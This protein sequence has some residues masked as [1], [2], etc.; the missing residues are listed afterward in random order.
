MYHLNSQLP[1]PYELQ[2]QMGQMPQQQSQMM[3]RGGRARH[4]KMI[5]A[6]G[7]PHELDILDHLQ[8]GKVECPKTGLRSYPHL[9]EILKNP[10]IKANVHHHAMQHHAAGGH[11]VPELQHLAHA[12]RH[13]DSEMFLMGPHTHHI[14][15]QLAGHATRN[16]HTGHPEYWSLGGALGGLWNGIKG[17]AGHAWNGIKGIGKA[18]APALINMGQSY[19]NNKFGDKFGGLAK[20]G[21]NALGGYAKSALDNGG[22]QNPIHQAIGEGLGRGAQALQGGASASQAFGQ[23]M[24]HAGQ[25]FGGG[26]LGSAMQG[27]GS[28]LAQGQGFGEAMKQGANQGFQGMGGNQ[29]MMDAAKNIISSYGKPGGMQGALGQQMQQIGNRALPSSEGMNNLRDLEEMPFAGQ[30]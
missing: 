22:E 3:A 27:M 6:H 23:G 18:A 24:Q 11:A 2:N 19:L 14:F 4:H 1:A 15:N 13:G 7:N 26:G 9:E 21:I 16:P 8:G 10:H 17:A 20:T 5:L 12:G 30:Y 25:Q 29:G 28:G